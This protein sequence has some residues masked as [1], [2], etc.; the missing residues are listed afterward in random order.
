MKCIHGTTKLCKRCEVAKMRR[1]N[2]FKKYG[3]DELRKSL[4]LPLEAYQIAS[5]DIHV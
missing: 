5:G 4:D 1:V 3:L 2:D